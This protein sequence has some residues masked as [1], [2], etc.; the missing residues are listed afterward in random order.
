MSSKLICVLCLLFAMLC[1]ER[2]A[3]CSCGSGGPE[4]CEAYGR[5]SAVF[6]GTV[7]SIKQRKFDSVEVERKRADAGERLS[8]LVYTF[9]VQNSFSG[10]FGGEVEVG[11]GRGGGD[12]GYEFIQGMQYVVYAYGDLP[13]NRLWTSTCTRTRPVAEADEDLAFLRSLP[14]RASGVTISGAVFMKY[15]SVEGAQPKEKRILRF[16]LVIDGEGVRRE[17]RTDAEGRYQ[18]TGLKA[19]SYV[20][21][22]TLPDELFTHR[23]ERKVA[24]A[25]RGCSDVSFYVEG[26]GRISGKVLDA[27]GQPV[28][29]LALYLIRA[30]DAGAEHP[31]WTNASSD[32]EGQFTFRPLASGR[33]LLGVR[34]LGLSAP[35][36]VANR[37]PLTF[38]PGVSDAAQA[39][40]ITVSRAGE[41]VSG[42]VLQL[43]QRLTERTVEGIVALPNNRPAAKALVSYQ[44]IS[45]TGLWASYGVETDEQG[46]FKIMMYEGFNYLVRAYLKV[47]SRQMHA[48]PAEVTASAE[49]KSIRLTISEPGTTCERC[50]NLGFRQSRPQQ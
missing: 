33:Y 13:N 24:I 42:L 37:Y 36:D 38:Y 6:V 7:V 18:V 28:P 39:T 12:C 9:A 29:K 35:G 1:T 27:D 16:P 2:A 50:R 49:L 17:L 25:E 5:A 4:P 23:D 41:H 26:N 3:A 44:E 20:V 32:E 21:K 11:S 19:G 15:H 14:R 8:P 46:R 47:G 48:E 45:K 10:M 30:E 40:P 31:Q 34:L 22:V 43:P